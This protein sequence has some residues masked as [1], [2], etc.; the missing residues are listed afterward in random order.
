M[1]QWREVMNDRA[2]CLENARKID[3]HAK[4]CDQSLCESASDYLYRFCNCLPPMPPQNPC[5]YGP[6]SPVPV[7]DRSGEVCYCC[8]SDVASYTPIA[9]PEGEEQPIETLVVGDKVL[10]AGSDLDWTPRAVG[11]S[12]GIPPGPD[13]GRTMVS[14]AYRLP[15]GA[16]TLVVTADHVFLLPDGRLRR[17]EALVPG[18]DELTSPDGRPVPIL[19][20]EVG[21]SHGGVH[22]IATSDG[23][24]TGVDGHLLNMKGVVAGDWALQC[25]E[26]EDGAIKAALEP[27]PA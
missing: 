12:G 21:E 15:G 2:A 20:V 27:A 10:S 1:K 22:H 19:S 8:C 13:N 9:V 24:A 3:P 25:A 7:Y 4:L 17:A 26:I 6:N 23:V 16:A 14:I 5:P 18:V 11:F